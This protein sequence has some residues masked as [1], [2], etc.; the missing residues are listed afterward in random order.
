M[1]EAARFLSSQY[2]EIRLAAVLTMIDIRAV[3]LAETV[4]D[5]DVIQKRN[6]AMWKL[7]DQALWKSDAKQ[8]S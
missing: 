8:H 7:F 4:A 2:P 6:R 5:L 1:Q 3:Q